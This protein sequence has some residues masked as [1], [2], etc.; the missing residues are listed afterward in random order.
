MSSDGKEVTSDEYR[1]QQA[2]AASSSSQITNRP[3][4][5]NAL[6]NSLLTQVIP[7]SEPQT[8]HQL[9]QMTS[10][11]FVI[12]EPSSEDQAAAA[13]I[14]LVQQQQEQPKQIQYVFHSTD[15]GE[16]YLTPIMHD[17]YQSEVQEDTEVLLEGEE[18]IAKSY[19]AN[20]VKP[21][22]LINQEVIIV[23]IQFAN[24]SMC[25]SKS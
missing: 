14:T 4:V 5:Q 16:E 20:P 2:A 3:P 19:L 7:S 22:E 15:T 11:P 12:H 8:S 6:V 9:P 13:A 18:E 25:I 10:L 24:I 21:E 17:I 23:T 1:R